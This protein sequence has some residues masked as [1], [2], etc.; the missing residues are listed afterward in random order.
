[1]PCCRDLDNAET[2]CGFRPIATIVLVCAALA[3][4]SLGVSG[5]LSSAEPHYSQTSATPPTAQP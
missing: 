4:A 3:V 5:A 2:R 1:M